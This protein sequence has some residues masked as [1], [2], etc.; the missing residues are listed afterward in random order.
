MAKDEESEVSLWVKYTIFFF[1][2]LFWVVGGALLGVGLWARFDKGW[3]SVES[4]TTDPA[5]VLI[6]VGCVTFIV[7][8]CG[9]LGALRENIFLLKIF[10]WSLVV[11]FILEV[12]GAI[13]AFVFRGDVEKFVKDQ[14]KTGIERYR[15]DADLQNFIDFVQ[16]QFECCGGK[17][18][19]DWVTSEGSNKYFNCTPPPDRPPEA[20]GVP[21][22]CC[23]KV[24]ERVNSQCG[25]G[26]YEYDPGNPSRPIATVEV[27]RTIWTDGCYD[28]VIK[29]AEDNL[30]ILGI[31]VLVVALVQIVGIGCSGNLIS[32][33][34]RQAAGY[35]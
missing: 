10:L 12:I 18:P 24:E 25:Y 8:F 34:K 16:Q 29:F 5:I 14:V 33:I 21:F 30:L 27:L 15:E 1:N 13:L 26:L 35:M 17:N 23:K 20:C 7:G 28:T 22:S 32:Q 9:C 11:L 6:V 19:I 4:L 31:I 3:E 2:L